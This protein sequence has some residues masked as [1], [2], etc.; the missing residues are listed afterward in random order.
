[1]IAMLSFSFG[2]LDSAADATGNPISGGGKRRI[3]QD[4]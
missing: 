4:L 1:M 2:D 3:F